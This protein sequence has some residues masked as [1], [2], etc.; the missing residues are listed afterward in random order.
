MTQPDAGEQA[1]TPAHPPPEPD[2]EALSRRGRRRARYRS[3]RDR[4]ITP[5]GA[6]AWTARTGARAVAMSRSPMMDTT[7]V[8]GSMRTVRINGAVPAP[9]MADEVWVHGDVGGPSSGYRTSRASPGYPHG[10]GAKEIFKHP[11][12]PTTATMVR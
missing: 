6:A 1:E 12:I 4:R 5:K 10:P 2:R 8:E 9:E 7:P 11:M 3:P